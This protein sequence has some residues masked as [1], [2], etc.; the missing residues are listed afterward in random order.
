MWR[1]LSSMRVL[2]RLGS[3]RLARIGWSDATHEEC[4]GNL[5]V[6]GCVTR[7]Q[8]KQTWKFLDRILPKAGMQGHERHIAGLN[9]PIE[10]TALCRLRQLGLA[11]QLY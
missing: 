8:L 4:V 10:M 3:K 9:F 1:S 6:P 7:D 2:V 5:A 11:P